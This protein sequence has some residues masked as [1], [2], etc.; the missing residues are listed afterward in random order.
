MSPQ[1]PMAHPKDFLHM[2]IL[3]LLLGCDE[4]HDISPTEVS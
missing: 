1:S 3:A 2:D 4:L